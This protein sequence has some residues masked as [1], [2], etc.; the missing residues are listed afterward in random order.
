ML[1]FIE[2]R[3][4]FVSPDKSILMSAIHFDKSGF[5]DALFDALGVEV[6]SELAR[7]TSGRRAEFLAGRVSAKDVLSHIGMESEQVSIGNNRAPVWPCGINGTISH[8][9][10]LAVSLVSKDY[11]VGIDVESTM[12]VEDVNNVQ[13]LIATAE[14]V[15]IV[16]EHLDGDVCRAITLIFSAKEALFKCLF[17]KVNQ[18]FDFSDATLTTFDF[19]KSVLT[20]TINKPL[21]KAVS[22]GYKVSVV[23]DYDDNLCVTA[24][25]DV[26]S[27]SEMLL[28]NV[29]NALDKVRQK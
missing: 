11:L 6:Q 3:Y 21:S 22:K 27:F 8:T 5:T 1:P 7:A 24:A 16:S 14:E 2:G 18:Y 13:S 9:G 29:K 4:S 25:L 23:C 10:N 17:P 28:F 19:D 20:F 12:S 15:G 26:S